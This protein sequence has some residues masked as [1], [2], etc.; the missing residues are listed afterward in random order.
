MLRS[1]SRPV[2]SI[3]LIMVLGGVSLILGH[4]LSQLQ[5]THKQRVSVI[6]VSASDETP[7]PLC[8]TSRTRPEVLSVWFITKHQ[9]VSRFAADPRNQQL[10]RDPVQARGDVPRLTVSRRPQWRAGSRPH[11]AAEIASP[12][13]RRS[14][15]PLTQP[16]VRAIFR[17]T[18]FPL[19]HHSK[20]RPMSASRSSMVS[21]PI[22]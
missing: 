2:A 20:F 5:D 16:V 4:A 7:L 10:D 6:S 3:T 22:R 14:V 11:P 21:I 15:M 8:T 18:L 12:P 19:T 9:D 1:A 17:T 13:T